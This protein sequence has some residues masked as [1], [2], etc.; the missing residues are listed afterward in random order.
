MVWILERWEVTSVIDLPTEGEVPSNGTEAVT[1]VDGQEGRCWSRLSC[2]RIKLG[3]HFAAGEAA[4]VDGF[5][6]LLRVISRWVTASVS[7]AQLHASHLGRV[8]D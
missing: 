2:P 3:D 1:R 4:S 8:Y 5:L 7:G 6:P